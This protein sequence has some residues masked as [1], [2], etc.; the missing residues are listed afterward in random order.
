MTP[1]SAPL[2]AQM[3][4]P[5]EM[6][7]LI[8]VCYLLGLGLGVLITFAAQKWVRSWRRATQVIADTRHDTP[9][10]RGDR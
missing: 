10:E 9:D 2:A 5:D 8:I 4:T 1:P 6:A 3:Y 7:T